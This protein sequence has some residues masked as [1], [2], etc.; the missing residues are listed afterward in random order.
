M[1]ALTHLCVVLHIAPI[2]EC[3]ALGEE[4]V[5]QLAVLSRVDVIPAAGFR[6]RFAVAV[7]AIEVVENI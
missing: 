2:E 5:Q 3:T 6:M 4:L 1:Q 7:I